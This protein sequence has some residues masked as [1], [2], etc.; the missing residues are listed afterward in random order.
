MERLPLNPDELLAEEAAAFSALSE[1]EQAQHDKH[2]SQWARAHAPTPDAQRQQEEQAE[3]EDEFQAALAQVPSWQSQL[4]SRG[5]VLGLVLGTLFCVVIHKINLGAGIVPSLNI[6]AGLLAFCS[7]KAYSLLGGRLGWAVTPFGAQEVNAVQTFITAASSVA[8]TGGF[9]SHLAAMSHKAYELLGEGAVGNRA[10]D[11][12]EPTLGRTIPYLLSCSMI[13]VFMLVALRKLMIIDYKLVYPSGT[14]TGLMINSFFTIKGAKTA[15]IQ[16]QHMARWFVI[17][18]TWDSFKWLFSNADCSYCTEMVCGGFDA[19]PIFGLAAARWTFYLSLTPNLIGAGMI[20]PHIVNMSLLSGAVMTWGILWPYI[21]TKEGDWYPAG[22]SEHDFSGLFG[23]KVFITIALFTGDG[24]YNLIKVMVASIRAYVQLSHA[25]KAG[26]AGVAGVSVYG[27]A[28]GGGTV[29]ANGDGHASPEPKTSDDGGPLLSTGGAGAGRSGRSANTNTRNDESRPLLLS[30]RQLSLEIKGGADAGVDGGSPFDHESSPTSR[31]IVKRHDGPAPA[32][33]VEVP[34]GSALETRVR[35]HVFLSDT[36]PPWIS[37]AGYVSLGVLGAAVI[38]MCFA[39]V[40]WYHVVIGFLMAPLMSLPVSFG[41]GLTDWD[42]SSTF[43]KLAIFLYAA[44]VGV[45]AGG[46]IT[47]LAMAG[48][49]LSAT[50]TSAT[51]MQDFKTGYL[52]KC[53][54]RAMFIAQLAGATAGALLAPLTFAMFWATGKVADPN[55][56]YPAPYAG[57]FRAMAIFGT[58]GISVLPRYCGWL[59]LAFFIGALLLNLARDLLP[60]RVGRYIPLALA[61]AIP[62]IL[63]AYLGIAMALGSLVVWLWEWRAGAEAAELY[64]P[65]VASGLIVGD[66]IFSIPLSLAGMLGVSAPLCMA[67]GAS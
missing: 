49:F 20:C 63:G 61:M 11:V 48:V 65:A 64:A 13:G 66:G 8:Y 60:P 23:Y 37:A 54:P 31:G 36:I 27:S 56:P 33:H 55:G 52:C 30:T 29:H 28:P 26:S 35:D 24:A 53:A 4:T 6:A 16:L 32:A 62:G 5:L 1:E 19:F 38:P 42:V 25:M 43:S 7:F 2:H 40:R 3:D 51:L 14:A 50:S 9:G 39:A 17:S 47:G 59:M 67:F 18:L 10:E 41:M 57:I 22:K 12:Y 34:T 58:R 45:Q 21:G 44:Y 46:V 15:A